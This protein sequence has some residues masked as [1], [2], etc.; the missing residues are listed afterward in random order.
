MTLTSIL[1]IKMDLLKMLVT[2]M[3]ITCVEKVIA[4]QLLRYR[5]SKQG[6]WVALVSKM[7]LVVPAF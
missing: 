5:G 6:S 1:A 4:F 2:V 3:K 7:T